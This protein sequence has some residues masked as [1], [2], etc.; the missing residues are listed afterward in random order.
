MKYKIVNALSERH[1]DENGYLYVD[2]S[3]ILRAGIL[4]YY[5]SELLPE[6]KDEV[7]GVKV[8]PDKVYKVFIPE[9]EIRKG[10]E[11]FKIPRSA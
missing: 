1:K 5:G 7:D 4:E 3:P 11:T 10:A 2:R 6:G 8:D 9:E